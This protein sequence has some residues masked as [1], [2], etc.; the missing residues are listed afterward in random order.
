L[1]SDGT[2]MRRRGSGDFGGD[3]YPPAGAFNIITSFIDT[4]GAEVR[5]R[6]NSKVSDGE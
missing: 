6:H 3:F 2:M 1:F 4:L 5:E